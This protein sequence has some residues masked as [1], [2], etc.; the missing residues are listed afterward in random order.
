MKVVSLVSK[1]EKIINRIAIFLET[2]SIFPLFIACIKTLLRV[3]LF[4][5]EIYYDSSV[6]KNL[7]MTSILI[8]N[9]LTL[10]KCQYQNLFLIK[11]RLHN[12]QGVVSDI[13]NQTTAALE[14]IN[15]ITACGG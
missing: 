14:S 4:T 9:S 13:E 15:L 8:T 1:K 12:F 11:D 10:K 7:F 5:L 6:S 2:L 3:F